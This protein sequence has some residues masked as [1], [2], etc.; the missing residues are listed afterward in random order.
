M[1][2][3]IMYEENFSSVED[4]KGKACR[5]KL[6]T[7]ERQYSALRQT[8]NNRRTDEESESI[9]RNLEDMESILSRMKTMYALKCDNESILL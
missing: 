4:N 9:E 8:A 2:D 6:D 5:A 1:K 7:F 3:C